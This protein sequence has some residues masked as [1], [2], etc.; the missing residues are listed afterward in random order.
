M[1][2]LLKPHFPDFFLVVFFALTGNYTPDK[3]IEHY[4]KEYRKGNGFVWEKIGVMQV[5]KPA[6][7][8]ARNHFRA[9]IGTIHALFH[10][11]LEVRLDF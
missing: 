10:A 4:L 11:L 6:D 3:G 9:K 1:A 8:Y 2:V 7:I 5:N